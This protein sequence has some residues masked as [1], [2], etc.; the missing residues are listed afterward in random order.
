MFDKASAG[1]LNKMRR[2]PVKVF[3]LIFFLFFV[4]LFVFFSWLVFK[5]S[6]L[7]SRLTFKCHV[8]WRLLPDPI[9]LSEIRLVGLGKLKSM[10]YYEE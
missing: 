10:R 2:G 7:S 3:L 5:S 6:W 9:P 1:L 8:F 4:G